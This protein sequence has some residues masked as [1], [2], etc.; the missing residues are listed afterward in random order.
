MWPKSISAF[1]WGL[2][3]S[4]SLMLNINY[5]I[6]LPVDVSLLVGL[7]SAF[8]LWGGV[9]V[10]CFSRNTVKQASITCLKIFVVSA[11]INTFFI[12]T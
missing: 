10:Y 2:V 1:I 11:S 4:I 5:L 7:L 6:P 9:M 8:V 12:L 3:L